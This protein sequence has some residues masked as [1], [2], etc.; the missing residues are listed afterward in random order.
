MTPIFICTLG[1]YITMLFVAIAGGINYKYRT[2]ILRRYNRD[3]RRVLWCTGSDCIGVSGL[4]LL[5]SPFIIWLFFL[6][7][8][9]DGN[10]SLSLGEIFAPMWAFFGISFGFVSSAFLWVEYAK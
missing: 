1:F 10:T 6:T 4:L 5:L 3:I 9:L 2:V 8:Y 7:V